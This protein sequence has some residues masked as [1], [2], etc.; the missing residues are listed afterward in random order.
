MPEPL[1]PAL[2]SALVSALDQPG[3]WWLA[4]TIFVAGV[5]RGF[6]GF[7]TAL[8][9]LPVAGIF[10]PPAAAILSLVVLGL[11]SAIVL[12]PKAWPQAERGDVAVLT[13]GAV[14][15]MPLGVALLV[16]LDD[17][18]VRWT[19]AAVAAVTLA[20]LL[21]GRRYRGRIGRAGQAAVG[22]MSGLVGG[23]TGLTGPVTILFY[24][25]S[26]DRRA[27]TVRANTILFLAL[28]DVALIANILL[29]GLG[30]AQPIWLG[31]VLMPAYMCGAQAGQMLF[32]PGRE[33]VYRAV[34]CA[35]IALAIATGL[36]VFD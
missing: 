12:I 26:A 4:L 30:G 36:P 16:L 17:A 1:A 20:L 34:A 27:A 10:L 3:L 25:G 5:V 24:L 6:T 33:R 22:A 18:T 11:G 21:S 14:A 19:I 8:I 7:G 31:L 2:V 23:A 35:V 32:R 15:A 9:Y 29:A 13:L 28:M